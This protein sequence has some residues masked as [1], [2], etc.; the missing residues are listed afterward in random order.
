MMERAAVE[1]GLAV[2]SSLVEWF[3][4]ENAATLLRRSGRRDELYSLKSLISS[5]S[6]LARIRKP[7]LSFLSESNVERR[8]AIELDG[9]DDPPVQ[10]CMVDGEPRQSWWTAAESFSDFI[11]AW[12]WDSP[13]G[14]LSVHAQLNCTLKQIRRFAEGL[15][16]LTT[17]TAWPSHKTFRYQLGD[18]RARLHYQPGTWCDLVFWAPN[19]RDLAAMLDHAATAG[20]PRKAFFSND[21]A[22]SKVIASSGS[23]RK[24]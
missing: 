24:P 22:A 15:T 23:R 6:E 13:A 11:F 12:I 21:P 16:Q 3:S 1:S 4:L 20:L 2:P 5:F 17:T 10:I 7:R 9:S 8:W 19:A 14:G 18:A